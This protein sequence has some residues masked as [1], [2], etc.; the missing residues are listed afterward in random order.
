[1]LIRSHLS[2]LMRVLYSQVKK[3]GTA[4]FH[5]HSLF[6]LD[7]LHNDVLISPAVLY[8][9]PFQTDVIDQFTHFPV[10]FSKQ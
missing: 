5:K 1:M 6:A 4:R 9:I 7:I 3:K 2:P 10:R 8:F